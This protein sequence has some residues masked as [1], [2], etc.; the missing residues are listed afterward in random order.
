MKMKEAGIGTKYKLNI[1]QPVGI[2]TTFLFSLGV[3]KK[4]VTKAFENAGLD[5][6]TVAQNTIRDLT[7]ELIETKA[8]NASLKTEVKVL[9]RENDE[10]KKQKQIKQE[11]IAEE[12]VKYW[13]SEMQKEKEKNKKKDR[14]TV[15]LSADGLIYREPKEKHNHRI[16]INSCRGKFLLAL[17]GNKSYTPTQ[18]II[19][20]TGL[21]SRKSVESASYQIR[22]DIEKKLGIAQFIDGYQDYGYRIN[23]G[24]IFK[25]V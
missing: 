21:S 11:K 23:P 25:K 19:N 9:L 1:R 2:T 10:Y 4:A 16:D 8:E 14:L 17:V 22:K 6:L 3:A 20:I 7:I 12:V 15:F 13:R 24:V 18:Q 5:P